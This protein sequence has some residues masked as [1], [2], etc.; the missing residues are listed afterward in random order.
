MSHIVYSATGCTRCKILKDYLKSRGIEYVEYDMKA[1]GKE[2]FQQFY[3]NNRKAIFRGPDGVEFPILVEGDEIRQ[4]IAATIAFAYAGTKLDGFFTV[5]T[6]HKEWVNG[7]HVSGGNPEYA[8]EF[9]TVLRE[10]KANNFKLQVETDGRNSAILQQVLDEALA[11]VVIMNVLG[12][13]E[14]Y[15]EILGVEVDPTDLTKS[16]ELV[17]KFPEYKFQTTIAPIERSNGEV[18]YLTP[19]EVGAAAKQIEEATGSKKNPYL[20]KAFDVKAAK[21][22]RFKIEPPALFTYRTKARAAQVMTDIE[23]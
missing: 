6:L 15:S 19:D 12:P 13:K 23:K 14:L 21:D 9:L 22:D 5:G 7:I 4:S 3:K 18:S 16:M 1:D 8:E 11:D 17:T 2:E 20:L 10:L